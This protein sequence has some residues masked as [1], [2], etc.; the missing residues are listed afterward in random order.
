[1]TGWSG[2]VTDLTFVS[3]G[4]SRFERKPPA[5]MATSLNAMVG[6]PTSLMF[7]SVIV[8][9]RRKLAC[10]PGRTESTDALTSQ[11]ALIVALS[12]MPKSELTSPPEMSAIV[13][14]EVAVSVGSVE[15][16]ST[17]NA[18]AKSGAVP[19]FCHVDVEEGQ[20]GLHRRGHVEAR[21]EAE[22]RCGL[23]ALPGVVGVDDEAVVG[24]DAG[25]DVQLQAEAVGDGVV[26]PRLDREAGDADVERQ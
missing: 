8:H 4:P 1:M 23:A 6:K 24:V 3:T 22:L 14:V 25:L 9:P 11:S 13:S 26:L 17:K 7:L 21:A 19:C 10:T 5:S 12:E 18:P 20:L 15:V 16:R 2:P